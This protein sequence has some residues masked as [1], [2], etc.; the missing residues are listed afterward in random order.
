MC[1]TRCGRCA[2]IACSPRSSSL[3]FALGIGANTAIFGAVNAVLL[4]PLPYPTRSAGRRCGRSI[5]KRA[6]RPHAG[7]A[8]RLRRLA[9]GD[10]FVRG[11]ASSSDGIFTL[12]GAGSS[13]ESIIGYR[14][15]PEMFGVS[16]CRPRSA[17]PSAPRRCRRRRAQRRA[18]APPLRRRSGNRRAQHRCSIRSRYIVVGVMPP[19]VPPSDESSSCGRR[20]SP[21]PEVATSRTR[22]VLRIVAR[23]RPGVVRRRTRAPSCAPSPPGWRRRIP[24]PIGCAAPTSSRCVG[25][26]SGDARPALLVLLARRRLRLAGHLAPTSPACRWRALPR[27]GARW[28]CAPRSARDAAASCS[29]F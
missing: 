12:T 13:P 18:V 10:S 7:R 16:A 14:F 24:T 29:S 9:R 19:G 22:R 4:Q 6:A 2:R 8:R 3:T 5:D 25:M 15:A 23:L 26:Y 17:G 28:R 21:P 20:S 11:M 27:A 1:A